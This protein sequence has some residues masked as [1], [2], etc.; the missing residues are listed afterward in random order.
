MTDSFGMD[1][2]KGVTERRHISVCLAM[3]RGGFIIDQW[4]DGIDAEC[5]VWQEGEVRC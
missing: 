5:G 4:C 2:G 1:G 3:L